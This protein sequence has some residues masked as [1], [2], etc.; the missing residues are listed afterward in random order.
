MRMRFQVILAA[1]AA[2]EVDDPLL[3][4]AYLGHNGV[5]YGSVD[6]LNNIFARFVARRGYQF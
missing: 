3:G 4:F 6:S 5:P 1:R 2:V